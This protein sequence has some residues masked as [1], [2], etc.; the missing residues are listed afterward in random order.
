MKGFKMPQSPTPTAI[1]STSQSPTPP[2]TMNFP[3]AMREIINGNK[4]TKL[5]WGDDQ[6][7]GVLQDALLMLH[8]SDGKS[9]NSITQFFTQR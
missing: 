6:F 7:Y 8:K 3:D 5:E 9:R 2:G 4:I 1:A